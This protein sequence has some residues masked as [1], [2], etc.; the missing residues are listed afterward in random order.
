VTIN[1]TPRTATVRSGVGFYILWSTRSGGRRFRTLNVL[2]E[3]NREA[4]AIEV[5]ASISRSACR[6]RAG[7]AAGDL[8][9]PAAALRL[10]NGPELTAVLFTDWCK[11]NDVELRFIQPG[12]PD[13]NANVSIAATAPRSSTPPSLRP[14]H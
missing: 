5:G 7:A 11:A 14:S 6:P 12:K 4:L 9:R 8:R 10:D 2:D 13:Q 3:A 1:R